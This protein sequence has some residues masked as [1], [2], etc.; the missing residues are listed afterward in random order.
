MRIPSRSCWSTCTRW[1]SR[2]RSA[3]PAGVVLRASCLIVAAS[4]T[5][6][7]CSFTK[8][9]NKGMS[10][11]EMTLKV[12]MSPLQPMQVSGSFLTMPLPPLHHVSRVHSIQM[13]VQ[14]F[15]ALMPD[16][17]FGT[18]Q[19]LVAL[20]VHVLGAAQWWCGREQCHERTSPSA[21]GTLCR[22]CGRRRSKRCLSSSR[23]RREP[24]SAP[25]YVCG[26]YGAGCA[27]IRAYCIYAVQ[28]VLGAS[29]GERRPSGSTTADRIESTR[30]KKLEDFI[31]KFQ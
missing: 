4:Y 22:N 21:V 14:N 27:H 6:H 23:R 31:T 30:L 24:P 9:V 17:D 5:P 18:F 16:N 28:S 13:F 12:V 20:K 3:P 15:L 10:K 7:C 11:A 2:T 1:S 26:G 8:Y 29:A 25:W 19:K